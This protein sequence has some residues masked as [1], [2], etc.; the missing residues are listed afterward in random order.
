MA[1]GLAE[2]WCG[3][4]GATAADHPRHSRRFAPHGCAGQPTCRLPALASPAQV[5][6][7][8]CAEPALGPRRAPLTSA[9]PRCRE[10]PQALPHRTDPGACPFSTTA[11]SRWARARSNA[12]SGSFASTGANNL[13]T[14][15]G[16]PSPGGQSR[17]A[18]Q[19]WRSC[20]RSSARL[21]RR[22]A[23]AHDTGPD[24]GA[25]AS[26]AWAAAPWTPHSSPWPV[27]PAY[28]AATA[29]TAWTSLGRAETR[30]SPREGPATPNS[31]RTEGSPA[32]SPSTVAIYRPSRRAD[33]DASLGRGAGRASPSSPRIPSSV[34]RLG[35]WPRA[36]GSM[37]TNAGQA[38][39]GSPCLTPRQ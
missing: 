13:P 10:V 36:S 37:R 4:A 26:P 8:E 17:Q 35:R 19:H 39:L 34:V 31:A 16:H 28:P 32:R 15:T 23:P 5:F 3:G 14:G 11:G 2:R 21:A 6:A 38:R 27:V 30:W 1:A 7:R 20:A 22:A 24:Q 9:A 18:G 12:R 25:R 29:R 33:D